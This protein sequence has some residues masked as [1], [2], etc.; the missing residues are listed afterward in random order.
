MNMSK[1]SD[2]SINNLKTPDR[3]AHTQVH[4][5]I[6]E[7]PRAREATLADL[8]DS[9]DNPVIEARR[10]SIEC[11]LD[12]VGSALARLDDGNYGTCE[13]PA[14]TARNPSSPCRIV[15]VDRAR[16]S[17]PVSARIQA[18]GRRDDHAHSDNHRR[19]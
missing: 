19:V 12:E 7:A 6:D 1:A 10:F 16:A 4:H 3:S 15:R 13:G 11:V 14:V 18:K 5:A 9:T 2:R 8:P 17:G